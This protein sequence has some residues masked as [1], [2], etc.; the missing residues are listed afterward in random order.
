VKGNTEI[1]HI[2]LGQLDLALDLLREELGENLRQILSKVL[3][4]D[5]GQ[6]PDVQFLALVNIKNKY[7]YMIYSR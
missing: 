7:G 3:S 4:K 6:R 1:Y 5:D 2:V